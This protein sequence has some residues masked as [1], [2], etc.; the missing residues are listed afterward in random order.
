M[1]KKKFRIYLINCTK[2]E[3]LQF[4]EIIEKDQIKN[5]KIKSIFYHFINKDDYTEEKA[6]KLI[7]N[8]TLIKQHVNKTKTE[9][10]TYSGRLLLIAAKFI[11]KQGSLNFKMLYALC[12]SQFN[13]QQTDFKDNATKDIILEI[14][15][16]FYSL[17]KEE[18]KDAYFIERTYKDLTK[19]IEKNIIFIIKI[20]EKYFFIYVTFMNKNK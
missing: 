8:V 20:K 2:N 16:R 11:K 7:V 14:N 9:F 6:I 17:T 18:M 12:L 10:L 19:K 13:E 1:E 5:K 4:A 15:S 3:C